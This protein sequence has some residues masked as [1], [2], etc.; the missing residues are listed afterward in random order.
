VHGGELSEGAIDDALRH[1]ITKL[2]HLH[3]VAAEPYRQRVIQLGEA[4][5]RVVVV[6]GMGVDLAR[7]TPRWSRAQLT[8]DTGFI[9]GPR[10]LIVTFHP[11]TLDAHHGNAELNAVLEALGSL[12]D[13]HLLFTLP[14]ADVGNAGFRERVQAFVAAHPSAWSFPSLG[15]M[16]YL[17]FVAASDGVVGNSSSGLIEAPALGVGTLNI[18]TRQDGRLRASSVIDCPARRRDIEIGL[19]QLLSPEFRSLLREIRNPYGDGGGADEVVRVVCETATAG[20][21]V[22]HFHDLPLP[23]FA[24]LPDA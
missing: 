10:N 3:F 21:V 4:P 15:F 20:L 12:T 19:E 22:K 11:V 2:S 24:L 17:S 16:R 6:G 9:F 14:N 13:T 1:A 5:E 8:H 23:A 7:H 18:G